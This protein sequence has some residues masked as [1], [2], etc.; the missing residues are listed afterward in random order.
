MAVEVVNGWLSGFLSCQ[1]W[2]WFGSDSVRSLFGI[3]F[4]FG[5]AGQRRSTSGQLQPEFAKGTISSCSGDLG[6]PFS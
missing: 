2:S 1:L 5:Q 6:V 4:G 3:R